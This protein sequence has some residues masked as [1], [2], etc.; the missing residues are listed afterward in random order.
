MRRGREKVIDDG[1]RLARS[2][3]AGGTVLIVI[4]LIADAIALS[5][6]L[7]EEF[8]LSGAAKFIAA[9]LI[10]VLGLAHFITGMFLRKRKLLGIQLGITLCAI[11][12]TLAVAIVVMGL[13][14]AA[15]PVTIFASPFIGLIW[16]EIRALWRARP[17]WLDDAD[18][19]RD[20]LPTAKGFEPI[21]PTHPTVSDR[22][23]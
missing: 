10:L 20:G 4:G 2:Y 14:N 6:F 3:I 1:A 21:F 23:K 9:S 7:Q 17:Y 11:W 19:A 16:M 12:M 22:G 5:W 8:T 18:W 13:L 15:L